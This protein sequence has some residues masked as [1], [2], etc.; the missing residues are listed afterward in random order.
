MK[1]LLAFGLTLLGLGLI[2]SNGPAWA[3]ENPFGL[4]EP[5]QPGRWGTVLLHGGGRHFSG[6]IRLEFVRLAGGEKARIVLMPSDSYL[7]GKDSDGNDLLDGGTA[8]DY[9]ARMADEYDRWVHLKDTGRI[10]DFRFL[11]RDPAD[12]GDRRLLS[13]L[14]TATGVWLPAHD[15]ERLPQ[16]FAADYPESASAFQ[17]AL[18]DVVARGGVVGGLGGGSAALSETIIA[19]SVDDDGEGGWTRAR[20]GF[21]LALLHGVLIDQ[22]F[23]AHAGGLERLSDALRNGQRLDR[24]QKQPG[25]ERRTIG[26]GVEQ[27]TA[28]ILS[29][30]TARVIGDGRGHLFLKGNGDR[31]IQWRTLAEG[32]ETVVLRP[33]TV[34]R[35]KNSPA[36]NN[37]HDAE[38]PFGIPLPDDG[39]QPGTVVLHGGGDTTEMITLFPTLAAQPV[40]RMVHCPAASR[41]F[42]PSADV[43]NTELESEIESYFEEWRSQEV[44]GQLAQLTFLTTNKPADANSA[45]FLRPLAKADALWFSGGDQAWLARLFVDRRQ[46][47]RFQQ[48]VWD[49][50]RRGGVVGGS[51]AGLAIMSEMMIEGN[52]EADGGP[53]TAHLSRGMGV[54]QHVLAEQ[55]FDAY[56]GRIER[57]TALL[58][59]HQA[60]LKVSPACQPHKLLGLA[61]EEDTALILQ[62][63]RLRVTGQ[64]LAHVFLQSRDTRQMSWHALHPGDVA[65]LCQGPLGLLLEL[66]DWQFQE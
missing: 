56:A 4:P 64:K 66:E 65:V 18:R 34:L 1:L 12:E 58:R 24:L 36:G 22:N 7:F 26:I 20:L 31:T 43:S 11:Y 27:G 55:H 38:N 6:D 3:V 8:A 57:L 63:N 60:L 46:P 2:D 39:Q 5:H 53:A 50:V 48:A 45:A 41:Y 17:L 29:G 14:K 9:E 52:A 19:G 35:D 62:S 40:P 13:L 47:T 10:G 44:A 16:E 15:Q 54:L 21:G 33:S 30:N 32:D 51:S 59:D 61:V 28:L 42:R 25:V 37:F 23:D 49:I